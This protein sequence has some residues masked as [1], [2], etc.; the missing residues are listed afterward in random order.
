MCRTEIA[1][2]RG[3]DIG[4]DVHA[5]HDAARICESY[6]HVRTPV[7]KRVLGHVS[8]DAWVTYS[9]HTPTNGPANRGRV[10]TLH[11]TAA[12]C[13]GYSPC[14]VHLYY[15]YMVNAQRPRQY[16]SPST[17]PPYCP[18]ARG[19]PSPDGGTYSST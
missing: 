7:E 11:G 12:V 13:M 5:R 16:P 1:T 2:V 17:M 19:L 10:R 4:Q 6:D 14:T 9:R 3:G 8:V 18:I 15:V